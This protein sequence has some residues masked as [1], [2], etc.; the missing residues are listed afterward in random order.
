MQFRI[1]GPLE[2]HDDRGVLA[3]GGAKPR[4]VL[5]I[6]LLHANQPVSA[7]HLAVALWGDDVPANT[8]RTVHVHVSRLRKALG[9]GDVIATTPAGYQ[10]RVLEGELDADRFATLLADGQRALAD[11]GAQAAAAAL[12]EALA[13]WHGPALADFTFESFAQREIRGLEEDRLNA[14]AAR[15]E[16]DLAVGRHASLVGELQQLTVEHPTR[17]RFA[18]YLVV[19][20]YRSGR[21]ADALAAFRAARA[22]LVDEHGIEPGRQLRA[23]EAQVLAHDPELDIVVTAPSL[24]VVTAAPEPERTLTRRTVTVLVATLGNDFKTDP[25]LTRRL[26]KRGR[27]QAVRIIE[28]HG[29]TTTAGSGPKWSACSGSRSPTRTTRSARSRP[30]ST[31]APR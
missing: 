30:R 12:H 28:A 4:A 19:A 21:Q 26:I 16:A 23:L 5:A 3:L 11:G 2:V 27:D 6:L 24:A 25:E 22:R 17:E 1:L 13:L 31:C 29:G 14:L 10:L 9:G 18:E 8:V 7:E 20:L 15:V